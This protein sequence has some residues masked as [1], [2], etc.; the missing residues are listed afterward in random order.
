MSKKLFFFRDKAALTATSV[1]VL[2]KEYGFPSSAEMSVSPS[3]ECA[4]SGSGYSNQIAMVENFLRR[5]QLQ[6]DSVS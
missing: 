3:A 1:P 4:L 6:L 5:E 2:R